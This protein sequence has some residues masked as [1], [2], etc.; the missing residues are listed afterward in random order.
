[1]KK[2]KII[3]DDGTEYIGEFEDETSADCFAC[4]LVNDPDDIYEI[5]EIKED[6]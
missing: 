1:M 4:L 5:V 2:F 6:N 3:L